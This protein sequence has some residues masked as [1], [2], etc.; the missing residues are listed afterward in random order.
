MSN[1]STPA[2]YCSLLALLD[3]IKLFSLEKKTICKG[4][5]SNRVQKVSAKLDE[6]PLHPPNEYMP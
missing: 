2:A 5:H 6:Q 3:V 4:H 1:F